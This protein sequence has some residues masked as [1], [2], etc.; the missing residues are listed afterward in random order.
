M[1][2][3]ALADIGGKGLF[4]KEIDEALLDGRIDIAVHSMKDVPTYLPAGTVLPCNLPREDVR[5]VFI[6][7]KAKSLADLPE[8]A[9]VGSASLRRQAQVIELPR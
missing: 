2:S 8:G 5:D 3:T 6:S 7:P 1:L 9:V 4:T